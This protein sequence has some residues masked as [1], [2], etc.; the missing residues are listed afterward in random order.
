MEEDGGSREEVAWSLRE[1]GEG[2]ILNLQE[3]TF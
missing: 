2:Q 1:S 3:K